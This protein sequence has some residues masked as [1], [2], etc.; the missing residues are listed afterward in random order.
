MKCKAVFI[1]MN[2][3]YD[4]VFN[5][6]YKIKI[7]LHKDYI[8]IKSKNHFPKPYSSFYSLLKDWE[9]IEEELKC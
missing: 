8:V 7:K 5:R 2:G 6:T 9:F 1:G 3:D 4:Y